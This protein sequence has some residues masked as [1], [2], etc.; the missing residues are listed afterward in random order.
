MAVPARVVA[1]SM[2]GERHTHRPTAQ[3]AAWSLPAPAN[4]TAAS[5]QIYGDLSSSL[6]AAPVNSMARPSQMSGQPLPPCAATPQRSRPP[7]QPPSIVSRPPRETYTPAKS[8]GGPSQPS[9]SPQPKARL[10]LSLVVRVASSG[11]RRCHTA[12][13]VRPRACVGLAAWIMVVY[14]TRLY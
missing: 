6:R 5:D 11:Q 7:V 3:Q 9:G 8:T 4:S 12:S 13:A 2:Y 14:H 10:R 1:Q